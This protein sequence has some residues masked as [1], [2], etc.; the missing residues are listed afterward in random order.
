MTAVDIGTLLETSGHERISILKIDIEGAE[1]NVFS[2]NYHSW[3]GKVD[4]LVIELHSNECRSIF[5]DAISKVKFSLSEC[6]ELTVCKKRSSSVDRLVP[7]IE[8]VI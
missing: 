7:F 6:D 2:S 8:S 1:S 5:T 3:I 4:N